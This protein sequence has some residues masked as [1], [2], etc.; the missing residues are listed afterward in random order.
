[1]VKKNKSSKKNKKPVKTAKISQ[2][3]KPKVADYIFEPST[4]KILL[5][6]LMSSVVIL[7]W[8]NLIKTN[9][10]TLYVAFIYLI[11]SAIWIL[12]S[13]MGSCILIYLTS[14][15]RITNSLGFLII[16]LLTVF[17]GTALYVIL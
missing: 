4:T 7:G 9:S 1:M 11:L 17:I 14:K 12:A 8:I 10:I 5:T 2:P 13:L 6:L 15:N 3:P 16:C